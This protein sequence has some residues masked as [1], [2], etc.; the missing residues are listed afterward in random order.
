MN[1]SYD[2]MQ[3]MP[4]PTTPQ[5]LPPDPLEVVIRGRDAPVAYACPKCGILQLLAKNDSAEEVERKRNEAAAH[6]MKVCVC[7]NTLDYHY[8]LRCKECRD[9]AEREKERKKFEKA[10]KLALEQYSDDPVY[11]EGHEGGLGDGYFSSVD[12]VLDYCE[13]EGRAVPEYVWACASRDFTLDGDSI[14]ERELEKQEMYDDAGDDIGDEART[15]LQAY[16]DVWTKEVNLHS[17]SPD[18]KRAVLLRETPMAS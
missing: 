10:E 5:F 8:Y 12:E 16:L 3:P 18:Y 1:Q 17:W 7:G 9:K 11:W 6:C 13:Q 2:G 15:R 14:I 4:A